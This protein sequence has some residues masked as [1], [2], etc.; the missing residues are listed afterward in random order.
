MCVA[1]VEMLNE[2]VVPETGP[3]KPVISLDSLSSGHVIVFIGLKG[4]YG[5]SLK[6]SLVELELAEQVFLLNWSKTITG[7]KPL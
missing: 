2:A 4:D 5:S 3:S 7:L 1:Y 6:N